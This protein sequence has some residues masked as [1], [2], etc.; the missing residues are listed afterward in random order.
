MTSPAPE[1]AAA[2]R[3]SRLVFGCCPEP[4]P[5]AV[6]AAFREAVQPVYDKYADKIGA[7]LIEKAVEIQK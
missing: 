4:A 1:S 5:R 7:D 3:L 2:P 6:E